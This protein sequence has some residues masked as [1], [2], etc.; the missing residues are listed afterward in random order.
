MKNEIKRIAVLGA[1]TMGAGI[2]QLFAMKGFDVML[3][4]TCE[5]DRDSNPPGRIKSSLEV[6]EDKPGCHLR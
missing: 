3:I 1:G 6:L 5:A 2:G 4:Y